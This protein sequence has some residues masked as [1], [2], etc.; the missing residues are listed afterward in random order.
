[1]SDWSQPV[2]TTAYITVL[3]NLKDRDVDALTLC[4]NAPSNQPV[5]TI[6]YLRASNK[7]QE[8][9]G[10]AWQDKVIALAGG[11][12]GATTAAGVRSAI[13]LGTMAVQDNS[14]VNITGGTIV[15]NGAGITSIDALNIATNR[16]PTAR[17]G[18][19]TA[20]S[21]SFLRGDQSWATIP[22]SSLSVAAVQTNNFTAAV[23]TLYPLNAS[24]K[25]V[26]LPTVVGNAGKRIVLVLRGSSGWTINTD[27]GSETIFGSTSYFFDFGQYSALILHADAN[28]S[29]WDVI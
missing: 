11:G 4:L 15:G 8:W 27:N 13:G 23:E 10:A 7:F 17:L 29:L 12:T 2:V 16:V 14:A 28:S 19:G 18:T 1:M 26:T 22:P 20:N 21:S 3:A 6:R 5:G 9:D 25:T 24:G